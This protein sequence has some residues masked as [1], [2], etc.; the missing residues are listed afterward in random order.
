VCP[1]AGSRSDLRAVSARSSSEDRA[2]SS[3]DRMRRGDSVGCF[4]SA[5]SNGTEPVI[6]TEW[7]H[8]EELLPP[9][10]S[11]VSCSNRRY[12]LAHPGN[13]AGFVKGSGG[14]RQYGPCGIFFGGGQAI[15][16]HFQKQ[17][18]D[19]KP[20]ALVSVDEGLVGD[21]PGCVGASQLN[22]AGT[23]AICVKLLRPGNGGCE[24]SLIS[25]ARRAAIESEKTIMQC[26][27]VSLVDPDRLAHLASACSVLR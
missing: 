26:K 17:N 1:S 21:D 16:V 18:A 24:Q 12:V 8:P 9:D 3:S 27:R 22:N 10:F 19:D 14:Q 7:G 13:K 25:H 2:S 11:I 15:A 6:L 20:C 5:D 4:H 23:V